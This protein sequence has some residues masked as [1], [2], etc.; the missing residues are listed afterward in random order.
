MGREAAERFIALLVGDEDFRKQMAGNRLGAL[1]Q[2]AAQ[3]GF[4]FSADELDEIASALIRLETGELTDAELAGV[5]GGV[6]GAAIPGADSVAVSKTAG[7]IKG[8]GPQG[9]SIIVTYG[10]G[11]AGPQTHE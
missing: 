2:F 1:A 8:L 10:G 6:L 3:R 5:A 4:E 11:I 7:G 9:A